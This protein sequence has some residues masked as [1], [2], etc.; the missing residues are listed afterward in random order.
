MLTPAKSTLWPRIQALMVQRWG[1]ENQNRLAREAKVGV[2]TIARIKG[3]DTSI[4]LDVLEKIAEALGVQ[5]WQLLCPNCDNLNLSPLALD[6]ALSLDKIGDD[7][8]RKRAYAVALQVVSFGGSADLPA[9]HPP[10]VQTT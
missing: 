7:K 8:L 9:L 6:L 3:T 2:A 10:A 4:G 1:G 5:S